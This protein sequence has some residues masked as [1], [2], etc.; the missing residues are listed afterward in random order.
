MN[1]QKPSENSKV[2]LLSYKLQR[3][4]SFIE[5]FCYD[6]GYEMDEIREMTD[7]IENSIHPTFDIG[8]LVK[9]KHKKEKE[10]TRHR[11][12]RQLHQLRLK[13]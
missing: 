4:K 3:Y 9:E 8:K 10:I 5:W 11:E 7:L 6:A 1:T 12:E 2:E 13:Y